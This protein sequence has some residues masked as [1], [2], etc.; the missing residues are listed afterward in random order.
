MEAQTPTTK[1]EPILS[2]DFKKACPQ[3]FQYPMPKWDIEWTFADSM[4]LGDYGRLI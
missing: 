1:E 2:S 3:D 4:G